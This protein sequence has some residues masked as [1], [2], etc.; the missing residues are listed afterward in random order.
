MTTKK[1]P[2]KK[3]A[4][5]GKILTNYKELLK[6]INKSEPKPW[7][8][9]PNLTKSYYWFDGH[10]LTRCSSKAELIRVASEKILESDFVEWIEVFEFNNHDLAYWEDMKSTLTD[11]FHVMP[12]EQ[13]YLFFCTPDEDEMVAFA[14]VDQLPSIYEALGEVLC[15][16]TLRFVTNSIAEI[17]VNDLEQTEYLAQTEAKEKQELN[18]LLSKY[19]PN[20]SVK[21]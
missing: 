11:L 20:V 4:V 13:K 10:V 21:V 5:K 15:K 9:D 19:L 6:K 14:P 8:T 1:K 12:P 3:K 7:Y 16:E 18:R 2:T 17:K